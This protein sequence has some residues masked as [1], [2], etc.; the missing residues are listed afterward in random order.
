MGRGRGEEVSGERIRKI[1]QQAEE[2]GGL[3]Q[4]DLPYARRANILP[5]PE[6]GSSWEQLHFPW[7][8]S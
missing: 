2:H 1:L 3:R 6:P 8:R 4:L 7:G 5:G